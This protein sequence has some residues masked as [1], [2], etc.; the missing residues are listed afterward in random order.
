MSSAATYLRYGEICYVNCDF[1]WQFFTL[2]SNKRISKVS[3]RFDKVISKQ[4]TGLKFLDHSV[5]MH[6]SIR[7]RA[8]RV[9]LAAFYLSGF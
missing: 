3:L 1:C 4:S 6:F 8:T 2:S 9:L 5:D 7:H